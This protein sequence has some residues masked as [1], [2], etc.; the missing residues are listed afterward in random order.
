MKIKFISGVLLGLIA[1]CVNVHAA[2]WVTTDG[3]LNIIKI[4][5]FSNPSQYALFDDE[6]TS[7]SNPLMLTDGS[8]VTVSEN[9]GSWTASSKGNSIDLGTR[10]CFDFAWLNNGNWDNQYTFKEVGTNQ[11]QLS[12]TDN[13]DIFRVV[14][15]APEC[16][17]VPIPATAFLLLSGIASCIS[18]KR[19]RVK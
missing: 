18:L 11:Y 15:V 9:N 4:D 5:L 6:D 13:Y 12:W 1:M 19:F 16:N 7:F 10:E 8:A 3:D 14:D 17:P 2:L